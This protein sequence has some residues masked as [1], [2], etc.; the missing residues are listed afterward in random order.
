MHNK[1]I[2]LTTYVSYQANDKYIP[3]T[4]YGTQLPNDKQIPA[5]RRID[6]KTIYYYC[7]DIDNPTVASPLLYN[8]TNTNI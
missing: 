1:Y 2:P 6:F 5:A 4:T 7:C 3:F 8:K